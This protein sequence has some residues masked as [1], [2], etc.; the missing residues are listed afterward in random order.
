[1]DYKE[2]RELLYN[3]AQNLLKEG[4]T[5]DANAKMT[6]IE[7]LDKSFDAKIKAEAKLEILKGVSNPIKTENKINFDKKNEIT[8]DEVF[9]KVLLGREI[10]DTE[11]KVYETVNAVTTKSGN[12]AVIPE[13]M[14]NEIIKD[15][16]ETHPILNDIT[17]FAIKGNIRLPKA[18]LTSVADWYDDGTTTNDGSVST[19]EIDLY[20]YDLKCNIDLSFNMKEM[21]ISEFKTFLIAELKEQM[22]NKLA[23]GVVNGKGVPTGS[24][25]HKAQP[26][27]IVTALEGE[28]NTPKVVTYSASNTSDELEAKLRE[29]LGILKS[30][31]KAGSAFY[32]KSTVIWNVLAGIK[33]TKGNNIFIPDVTAGGV[34][35]IFGVPVKEEDAIADDAVLLGNFKRGYVVNFNKQITILSQDIN[36]EAK[37]SYT[38][39]AIVDGKPR[40]TEAFAYLKKS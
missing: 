10:N 33:D 32:A 19:A 7:N 29:M 30:G 22:A 12:G 5:E 40:L 27:G 2:K 18:S 17:T 34:G 28:T 4:K 38:G 35:R 20:G 13:T 15:L 31:Y 9:C 26:T 8:Y 25:T 11:R 6:E 3:E 14:L 1:M 16:G 36:K 37:T 39:Y 21:S 24:Q 23:N